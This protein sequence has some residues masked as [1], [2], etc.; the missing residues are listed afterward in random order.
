MDKNTLRGL[1]LIGLVFIVFMWL[2]PKQEN[3]PT[4]AQQEQEQKAVS[5]AQ[6]ALP[7]ILSDQE[8]DWLR[9][10]IT[11]HGTLTKLA[12]G[13]Q[14][15][16]LSDTGYL[17]Q[18]KG[19]T[20]TGSV[21][22]DGRDI[23]VSRVIAGD[24]T[25]TVA[26]RRQAVGKLTY[27][28]ESLARFGSFAP[29]AAGQEKELTLA[30][31]AFTLTLST[32]GAQLTRAVLKDYDTEFN[33][34]ETKSTKAPVVLFEKGSNDLSFTLPVNGDVKTS[35][36]YFTPLEVNDSSVLMALPFAGDAYWGLRYT[37]K[38]GKDYVVTIAVEQKGMDKVLR[39]NGR[40][41]GV[42]WQQA[43]RRQ[44]KGKMFEERNS[45]IYYMFDGGSV[46]DL[47]AQGD[48]AEQRQMKV[49]WI[50]FKNQFF[51]SVLIS[52]KP[53]NSTDLA[54]VELKKDDYGSESD[55][56]LKYMTAT[57]TVTDYDW[58]AKN[59][60]TFD[61]FLGPN[62]YPL[63]SDLDDRIQTDDDLHLTRMIPLGWSLFR[64]INT[65]VIIPVFNFLGSFNW[66]YGIIILLLTIFI[67]I[68]LFPLTYKSY[69]SQAK[70]RVLAPD[71][72]AINDKY[73]GQ[74]NAMVRQQK[75]M[76][77][78]QKAGAS[79]LSGCLPL[80][81]QM[82]ILFAMFSFFPSAIELRGQSFLW[83]H[84]LS[85]PD[86]IISWN[87][88]IPLVSDYFGNHI[89]LFCLLMTVTNIIYTRINMQS[90][91]AAGTPGMKWMMYLMPVFFMI[92][93]NNYAAGLS[94]YYF[95]SLLITIVQTYA[96]RRWFVKEDDV[97]KA[98]A[99][100][101]KKPR[102]K[103]GFMARLEE[104]Q[105]KQQEMLKQ[106]QAANRKNRR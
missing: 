79:P 105:R 87:T 70:M 14:A 81:L 86:A 72:K 64:W 22:V 54:S 56:F 5:E 36:L 53:F 68:V 71:V 84:D 66:N 83:C 69:V 45:A 101:A 89:S 28:R 57:S 67:K 43:L 6:D 20:I 13:S 49:K 62:L 42:N 61:L 11:D 85:A 19:D 74:E 30:N 52:R 75:T 16:V 15:R 21:K 58:S 10:N 96:V 35:D 80:L 102:K 38:P 32:K 91:S 34:D 51:S 98:M 31:D 7:D 92:F 73:P 4:P 47:N 55:Y 60:A 95:L 99:A 82:P 77:L 25:L 44:E 3:Q 26:D 90:Q 76:A 2:S 93:F 104:A 18:L 29:F 46:E 27:I 78:Y 97:R 17:L 100:N 9:E 48:D 1:V 23:D 63:L 12:D 106:Q 88:H 24:S 41:L 40:E 39:S 37:I 59:P 33:P 50:G 8:L 94:Y 65:C 103:S